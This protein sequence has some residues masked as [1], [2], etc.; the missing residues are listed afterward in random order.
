MAGVTALAPVSPAPP[1]ETAASDRAH[2][3]RLWIIGGSLLLLLIAI[4]AAWRFTPLHDYADTEA[5][6]SW[7]HGLRRS[8]WAPL[9]IVLVYIGANAVFFPNTVLNA[10]TIL[11][12]G[13]TWGLPCALLGSLS[14]ALVA[15]VVGRRYGKERLKRLDSAAI[16]RI[17]AMLKN[18]GVIGIATLRLVP[19]APYNVVNLVAGAARVRTVPFAIG[20]AI[21]LLP[22]NLLMTAFGH[23]LRAVLR[24]PG[25]VEIAAMAGVVLL[26]AGG[27]WW[28]RSRALRSG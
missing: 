7:L 23:Q 22:G 18:S 28:A 26:A 13:T 5:I 8:P 1:T 27:A 19:I 14:A 16:E 24:N 3:R 25:K 15:F 6:A 10:A 11:G 4:A 2:A 21:G 17:S 12:L 9:V 20:T